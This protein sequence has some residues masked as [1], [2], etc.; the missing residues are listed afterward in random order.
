MLK[1][2]LLPELE[3]WPFL[4]GVVLAAAGF[5]AAGFFTTSSSELESGKKQPG[6][7]I[8]FS[9]IFHQQ[10]SEVNDNDFYRSSQSWTLAS[11]Q[12]VWAPPVWQLFFSP[13]QV[14]LRITTL[15]DT[16]KYTDTFRL[17]KR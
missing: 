8:F 12:R 2:C 4:A 14:L 5:A 11:L 13:V 9:H 10:K 15:L 7:K 16:I 3:V 17:G 1:I 6:G